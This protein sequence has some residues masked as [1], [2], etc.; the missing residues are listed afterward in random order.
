MVRFFIGS[1]VKLKSFFHYSM[2]T[3]TLND[4]LILLCDSSEIRIFHFSGGISS[5]YLSWSSHFRYVISFHNMKIACYIGTYLVILFAL[6]RERFSMCLWRH[7]QARLATNC[8]NKFREPFGYHFAKP[9]RLFPTVP[10][11]SRSVPNRPAASPT[12]APAHWPISP[13]LK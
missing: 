10:E 11:D 6:T 4:L 5:I 9:S 1:Q 12:P 8:E 3:N 2:S 7:T 13:A